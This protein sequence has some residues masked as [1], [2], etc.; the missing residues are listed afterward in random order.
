MASN[1]PYEALADKNPYEQLVDSGILPED[2]GNLGAFSISAGRAT[3]KIGQGF[4][5]LRLRAKRRYLELR[6]DKTAAD[7]VQKEIDAL[8]AAEATKDEIYAPVTQQHP[9]ATSLGGAVPYSLPVG[10][11]LPSLLTGGGLGFSSYQPEFGSR[12]LEGGKMGGM[13]AGGA[14]LGGAL[15]GAVQPGQRVMERNIMTAPI[16]GE[17]GVLD[18]MRGFNSPD[19]KGEILGN[20]EARGYKPYVSEIGGSTAARQAEDYLSRAPGSSG[21]MADFAGRNQRTINTAAAESVGARSRNLSAQVLDDSSQRIGQTFEAVAALPGN[22]IRLGPDV[23]TAAAEVLRTQAMRPISADPVLSRVAHQLQ[24]Y[25]Q[26]NGRLTGEAYNALRSDL[27]AAANQAHRGGNSA[28]GR[29]YDALLAAVDGSAATSLQAAGQGELAGQLAT[30][31][32]QYGNLMTLERGRT[33]SAGGDVNPQ[34]LS[35]AMRQKYPR[36]FREGRMEGNPL[37]DIA[38][39]GETYPP[40]RSG[41]QTFER[42]AIQDIAE[43]PAAMATGAERAGPSMVGVATAPFNWSAAHWLTSP[44]AR[45]MSRRG[46]LGEPNFS[47]T[48]GILSDVVARDL[49]NGMPGSLGA[50]NSQN[51]E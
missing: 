40:L 29:A 33:V 44:A 16:T 36:Q 49:V 37:F 38:R 13:A 18:R 50:L 46:L 6:G 12:V 11:V 45:F 9:V 5:D 35:G 14:L 21:V 15:S 27:S 51:W 10:G 24:I 2:P 26:Y 42:Q 47:A 39:Y 25:S 34:A 19:A 20:M 8:K 32:G 17:H 48:G 1:N 4:N 7:E 41:S 23:G 43:A 3:D 28:A 31:R 30:A 22:P